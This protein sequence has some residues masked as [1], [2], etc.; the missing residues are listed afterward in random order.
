[1]QYLDK[2]KDYITVNID[3]ISFELNNKIYRKW[4]N[5]EKR[6]NITHYLKT[7]TKELICIYHD[8]KMLFING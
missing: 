3:S 7:P 6:Q 8:G 1:M 5:K 2:V 4:A